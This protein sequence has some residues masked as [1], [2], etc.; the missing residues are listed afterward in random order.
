MLTTTIYSS[1][2]KIVKGGEYMEK[3]DLVRLV[4]KLIEK[5]PELLTAITGYLTYKMLKEEKAN[6]KSD[7]PK[8]RKQR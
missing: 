6:K 8:A 4:E 3:E 5:T 7:K 1:I 2:I